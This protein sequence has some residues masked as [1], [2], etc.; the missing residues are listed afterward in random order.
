M[1]SC[2]SYQG[3]PSR[4][5]FL[6]HIRDF[7][8]FTVRRAGEVYPLHALSSRRCESLVDVSCAPNHGSA[9]FYGDPTKTEYVRLPL[10]C[11]IDAFVAYANDR[12]HYLHR[13]GTQLYLSQCLV[14]S[15]Q[16]QD[17]D[18][19]VPHVMESIVT[20]EILIGQDLY[21][22]NL[23][24]NI[25]DHT[26]SAIHYDGN[27]NLLCV[28][29]GSKTVALI[30]PEHTSK[31]Q[32]YSAY[33]GTPNHTHLSWDALR[34]LR[35]VVI[36]LVVKEGEALFIPEGWWHQ[37]TSSSCTLAI[38]FWFRSPLHSLLIRNIMIPYYLR[39]VVHR[40][41]ESLVCEL[42]E[43][44]YRLSDD[45]NSRVIDAMTTDIFE[46]HLAQSGLLALESEMMFMSSV[47]NQSRLWLPSARKVLF[48]VFADNI[49]D[50]ICCTGHRSLAESF[51]IRFSVC[52]LCNHHYLG[53]K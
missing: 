18:R 37:V 35:D 42:R 17:A 23:W 2:V 4:T 46:L 47:R 16:E 40:L 13:E 24:M 33:C 52:R 20:P 28:Q 30:S 7:S 41:Q 49:V 45:I 31:L 1:C 48:Y 53:E 6:Q 39:A 44:V 9:E 11:Y 21:E 38:N 27:H 34:D 25:Y 14:Y 3:W 32:P 19:I 36:E 50:S 5:D 8:P 12:P 10:S 26:R 22:V 51:P 29:Q 43:E 15:S